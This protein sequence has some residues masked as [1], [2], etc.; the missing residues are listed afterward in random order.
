[1]LRSL[2]EPCYENSN[3][4]NMPNKVT[5]ASVTRVA[6]SDEGYAT[7]N[8]SGLGSSCGAWGEDGAWVM[9][10]TEE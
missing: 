4:L 8:E 9:N 5:S 3:P 1:M 6:H 7:C 2:K 10:L